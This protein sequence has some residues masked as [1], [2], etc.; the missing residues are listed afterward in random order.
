MSPDSASRTGFGSFQGDHFTAQGEGWR[1]VRPSH[2]YRV[3]E[4]VT[5]F[6]DPSDPAESVLRRG[7]TM[8]GIIQLLVAAVALGYGVLLTLGRAPLP[9]FR[10]ERH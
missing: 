4:T 6:H 9:T 2:R 7:T 10:W 5:V 3:G 8:H 1:S